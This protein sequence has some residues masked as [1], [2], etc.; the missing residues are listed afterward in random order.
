MEIEM[1]NESGKGKLKN[2]MGVVSYNLFG[3]G[4]SIRKK[5]HRVMGR[6]D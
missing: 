2:V 6:G 4:N 3:V 1:G 5:P